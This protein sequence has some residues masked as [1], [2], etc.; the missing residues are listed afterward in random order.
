MCYLN[1]ITKKNRF[2]SKDISS[3]YEWKSI[4]RRDILTG[5]IEHVRP[6]G[7]GSAPPESNVGSISG[8]QASICSLN[9]AASTLTVDWRVIWINEKLKLNE[10]K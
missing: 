7:E 8:S 6:H 9:N 2:I 5:V 4:Q 3:L 1:F 10:E